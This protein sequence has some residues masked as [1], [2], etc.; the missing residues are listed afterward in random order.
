MEARTHRPVSHASDGC[1]CR[2]CGSDMRR[3][4]HRWLGFEWGRCVRCRSVQKIIDQDEYTRLDPSYDPGYGPD[5]SSSLELAGVMD[6]DGKE[7][8]LR[9]V[10]PG[11]HSGRMLD[12]GCGMGGYLLA[13]Q[14]MGMEVTGV[15]PSEPHGRAAVELF[16]LNVVRGYFTPAT[17]NG[18]FDLIVL[19]H[20]IEHIYRPGE[21]LGGLTSVLAPGGQLLVITPNAESL[22]ATLLGRYW[23]MYKPVDHVTM[24]GRSAIPFLV[25]RGTVLK[26][27]WTDEWPGEF[28]ANAAS[29]ARTLVHPRPANHRGGG[30]HRPC[31]TKA[32][33]GAIPRML[34]AVASFPFRALGRLLDRQAC[35]YFVLAANRERPG[36]TA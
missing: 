4:R 21:F 11:M 13:A 12:V 2:V 24:I 15:E 6:V 26:S 27:A 14:R 28:L 20:V 32:S 5:G 16:G 19:S 1:P 31:T 35:L 29:A 3:W 23:S 8:L 18:K 34:L 9:H 36:S 25:P 17:V 10:F 30:P 22:S 7:K 33:L